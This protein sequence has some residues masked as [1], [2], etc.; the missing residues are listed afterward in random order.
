MVAVHV[1]SYTLADRLERRVQEHAVLAHTDPL[2]SQTGPDLPVAFAQEV[3][4][5][6][7]LTRSK[8]LGFLAAQPVCRVVM[9]SVRQRPPLGAADPGAR[10]R[11]PPDSPSVRVT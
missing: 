4:L 10:P 2:G 8:L 9:E 11:G 7:K 3:V 6:K 1:G 5:R